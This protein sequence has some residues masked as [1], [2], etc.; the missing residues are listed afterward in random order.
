[1]RAVISAAVLVVAVAATVVAQPVA[2]NREQAR[3]Q[4]R[5]GWEHMRA[6]EWDDAA[7]AF[8]RAIELDD[9]YEYA[10]YGLGRANL[11]RR[12]YAT[13]IANLEDAHRLYLAQIGRYFS[14]TQEAQR[15]RRDQLT[16][17]DQQ[18]AQLQRL[19][20]TMQVA[21]QIR[22]LQNYRRDVNDALNRG[23][24]HVL[25]ARVPAF[26][27]LSLGSAYFRAG[28]LADAERAY[29]ETIEADPRSGEA[30][31]NLAVV[32]LET[33]RPTEA[34]ASLKAAKSAGFK[35]NPRLEE[36][37]RKRQR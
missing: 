30:H 13:A 34:M 29:K 8:G 15:L 24:N 16:E 26:V 33:A 20:Q 18:I 27:S 28:R 17:I 2:L 7:R 12:Q 9:T 35:V 4:N 23:T 32:Y 11:A 6:E 10:H 36:E 1:M 14:G 21:D 22:Q 5:L 37:I 25:K 3:T 31:N 19:P